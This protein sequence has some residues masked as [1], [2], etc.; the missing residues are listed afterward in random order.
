MSWA[1]ARTIAW[2]ADNRDVN[3]RDPQAKIGTALTTTAFTVKLAIKIP[4]C[5]RSLEVPET[6]SP[7]SDQINLPGSKVDLDTQGDAL[8]TVA[9]TSG[10]G[11]VVV[12]DVKLYAVLNQVPL[13]HAGPPHIWKTKAI[14]QTIDTEFGQGCDIFVGTEEPK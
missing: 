5:V 3:Q 10:A 1:E 9:L 14:S 2:V 11:T 13:L 6:F 12:T 7:C 8:T 4:F